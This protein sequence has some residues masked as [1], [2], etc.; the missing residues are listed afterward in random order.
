MSVS[1]FVRYDIAVAELEAF[2]ARYRKVHVPL[3]TNW[4]G[5]R[6]MVLHTPLEW[7]DP[8]PVKRGSAVLMAQLEFDSPEAM[9]AAF[10]S[11]ERAQAREDFKRF[12]TY[13][14]TVTHQA[15]ASEEV[16]RKP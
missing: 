9:N 7:R 12:M 10:A 11:R 16:W 13:E 3:V 1:Y 8:I 4:P 15:M 2:L 14:G 5:L 6:R